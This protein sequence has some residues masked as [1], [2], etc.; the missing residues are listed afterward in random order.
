ME[1]Q[2]RSLDSV[3]YQEGVKPRVHHEEHSHDDCDCEEGCCCHHHGEEEEEEE[4]SLSKIIISAVLFII[5]ILIEHIFIKYIP[6][7]KPTL[8]M[9]TRGLSLALYA[10]AY[11]LCGLSMIKEAVENLLHGKVFGEDFLMAVATIGAIVIGEYSEAVAVMILFQLGE[12]FE[13]KA[14]GRTRSSIT[15]LMDIRPDMARVKRDNAFTE[16]KPEEVSLNE[17]I[18]VRPGEKVPLDGKVVSGMSFVDTSALT[19]ESVPREIME[20]SDVLSGFINTTGVIEVKVTKLY[21]EGSVSRILEM[22]ENAQN[23]KAKTERF[24]TRFSHKYTPIVCI[25]AVMLAVIPSVVQ[26]GGI[27]VW[28]MWIYRAL[29]LLVVSCPCAFVISVP[30]SFFAGIGMTSKKGILIKGAAYVELLSKTKT[31]V[32]DKTGTLTKGVF[33]VT[34]TVPSLDSGIS[35]DDLIALATHAEYYSNHPISRSLKHIHH[36]PDCEKLIVDAAQE[37][38]GHGVKCNLDGHVILAGN[39]RLMQNNNVQGLPQNVENEEGTLVYVSKDAKYLGYIVIS[40]IIKEDSLTTVDKLKNA[41]VNKT[42]MLTGDSKK[43]AESVAQKLGVDM[44]YADLLPQDKVSHIEDLI[45]NKA[46]TKESLAFV[47]DGINDAPVLSRS[48]VGI[49]MGAMGSDAA[50]EAA[51]VIIM[52]D[53]PSKVAEAIRCSQ[54]IMR[55]VWSNVAFALVT[56]ILIM[57]LCGLG[58]TNMW[59]AVFGDVGVTMIAVLNSMTLLYGAK[60]NA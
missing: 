21:S 49:A 32:F 9:A 14:V 17:I 27:S 55:N 12:Y 60:K 56:K 7:S 15:S 31:V 24:I 5:A 26:G 28:K 41:G 50:L 53:L 51:D 40:D 18:E 45:A 19:G 38:S 8:I 13:D 42:V 46:S 39:L 30:L 25:I 23:K 57:I 52:D 35:K 2:V 4:V 1:M 20:G 54:K 3:S 6:S 36:C 37:I 43:V 16:V 22:V 44:L 33:E 10:I 58:I 48:D 34:K 47:G 11:L 59:I 29:E